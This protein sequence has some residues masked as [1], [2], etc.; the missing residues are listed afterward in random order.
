MFEP[1]LTRTLAHAISRLPWHATAMSERLQRAEALLEHQGVVN[2]GAN[3][4]SN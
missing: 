2:R 1:P 4:N 3:G